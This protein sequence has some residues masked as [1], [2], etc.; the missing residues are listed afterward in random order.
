ML[1]L[2]QRLQPAVCEAL[3]APGAGGDSDEALAV[4]RLA[5]AAGDADRANRA[6]IVLG[7]R[8]QAGT[9]IDGEPLPL[10]VGDLLA[11]QGKAKEADAWFVR[12]MYEQPEDPRPVLRLVHSRSERFDLCREAYLRGERGLGFMRIF[13]EEAAKK[14]DDLLSLKLLDEI[15]ATD[16]FGATDLQNA[17]LACISMGHAD[18]AIKRL[19]DHAELAAG[20]PRLQ[21][22]ELICELSLNGLSERAKQ[23]AKDWRARGEADP[24]VEG[25][26]KRYG[27]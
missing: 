7:E 15:C 11:G 27:G 25:L 9:L 17:V 13:A 10:V 18:W 14:G 12:A 26:L 19:A 22:L 2:I 21:R 20:E 6:L 24:F 23:L 3:L 16:S 8:A 1:D 4:Y 5:N